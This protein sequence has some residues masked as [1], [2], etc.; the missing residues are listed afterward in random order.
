V[1]YQ[2]IIENGFQIRSGGNL[3][4]QEGHLIRPEPKENFWII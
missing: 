4:W 3:L 2:H 1:F